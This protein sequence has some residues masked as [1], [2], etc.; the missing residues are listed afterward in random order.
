MGK[1]GWQTGSTV[2]VAALLSAL[3]VYTPLEKKDEDKVTIRGAPQSGMLKS[4]VT[5]FVELPP[6]RSLV[7]SHF[8]TQLGFNLIIATLPL[9][10]KY[11]MAPMQHTTQV[12]GFELDSK[13][14]V[15]VAQSLSQVVTLMSI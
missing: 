7:L 6:F 5:P 1:M 12:L 9:S 3:S 4:L 11:L 2:A 15:A 10:I 14:Q 8:C 13:A